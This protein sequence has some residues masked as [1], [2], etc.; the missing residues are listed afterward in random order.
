MQ[1]ATNFQ[2]RSKTFN[3]RFMN[4]AKTAFAAFKRHSQHL[5]LPPATPLVVLSQAALIRQVLPHIP[6]TPTRCQLQRP[7]TQPVSVSPPPLTSTA[8]SCQLL[9][10]SLLA[11][12]HPVDLPNNSVCPKCITQNSKTY[13]GM[14]KYDHNEYECANVTATVQVNTTSSVDESKNQETPPRKNVVTPQEN[15]VVRDNTSPTPG[16]KIP[17]TPRDWMNP[18]M[19]GYLCHAL[20]QLPGHKEISHEEFDDYISTLSLSTCVGIVSDYMHLIV[21]LSESK[22]DP[23]NLS[24]PLT[25]P[26]SLEVDDDD[27]SITSKSAST[28]DTKSQWFPLL[29]TGSFTQAMGDFVSPIRYTTR[30]MQRSAASTNAK[31]TVS[32]PIFKAVTDVSSVFIKK[33]NSILRPDTTKSTAPSSSQSSTV[34]QT[35]QARSPKHEKAKPDRTSAG[36]K[37]SS[38]PEHNDNGSSSS[39]SDSSPGGSSNSSFDGNDFPSSDDSS[40]SSSESASGHTRRTT[41]TKKPHSRR[42]KSSHKSKRQKQRWVDKVSRLVDKLFKKSKDMQLEQLSLDKTPF[43]EQHQVFTNWIIQPQLLLSRISGQPQIYNS[44]TKEIIDNGSTTLYKALA[45]F[46]YSRLDTDIHSSLTEEHRS[47]GISL[48]VHLESQFA[49]ATSQDKARMMMELNSIHLR[50]H[51]TATK[52]LS[53]YRHLVK[54]ASNLG[55][56]EDPNVSYLSKFLLLLDESSNTKYQSVIQGFYFQQQ[57]Q[58]QHEEAPH[59][60]TALTFEKV[61]ASLRNLDRHQEHQA[62]KQRQQQYRDQHG[63]SANESMTDI[64]SMNFEPSEDQSTTT[65]QHACFKCSS[66]DHGI[67]TCPEASAAEKARPYREWFAMSREQTN[68]GQSLQSTQ[69]STGFSTPQGDT[70]DMPSASTSLATTTTPQGANTMTTRHQRSTKCPAWANSVEIIMD[71]PVPQLQARRHSLSP[72]NDMTTLEQSV[73]SVYA[74]TTTKS[75]NGLIS[76]EVID[77][78]ALLSSAHISSPPPQYHLRPRHD[79]ERAAQLA[80]PQIHG[81]CLNTQSNLAYECTVHGLRPLTPLDQDKLDDIEFDDVLDLLSSDDDDSS[82]SSSASLSSAAISA[83]PTDNTLFDVAAGFLR[84]PLQAD[85]SSSQEGYA[86]RTN[87]S[88]GVPWFL[89]LTIDQK[90]QPLGRRERSRSHRGVEAIGGVDQRTSPVTIQPFLCAPLTR[91]HSTHIN[92]PNAPCE[93]AH[94]KTDCPTH[95]SIG[96]AHQQ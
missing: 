6:M 17:R 18:E 66:T 85:P 63:H 8:T 53:R 29:R 12:D 88:R 60:H 27:D 40:S 33:T 55:I 39:S 28:T 38:S 81:R 54:H 92:D 51:E 15:K 36:K 19:Y 76:R 56:T 82:I 25:T 49:P 90:S 14:C 50:Q 7:L 79:V 69:Q 11:E 77:D 64:E 57:Q 91:T 26:N 80:D 20:R 45:A 89:R 59:L 86:L 5:P 70:S 42:K 83:A 44:E 23:H 87:S 68:Y 4:Y 47:N 93:S 96:M 65:H 84:V 10:E 2:E 24:I 3:K 35:G 37:T 34:Q 58:Q 95:G 9:S 46:L 94:S 22:D 72:A 48:L 32:P 73:N 75:I 21:T 61:E 43:H 71:A 74:C 62:Y 1:Y 30:S 52:F 67:Q 41:R 78:R 16:L 13:T 31:K